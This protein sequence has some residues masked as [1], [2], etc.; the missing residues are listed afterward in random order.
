[1]QFRCQE[2]WSWQE[3]PRCRTFNE[4]KRFISQLKIT[5]TVGG[6]THNQ[7]KLNSTKI[8]VMKLENIERN[9]REQLVRNFGNN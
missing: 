4:Q 6:K 7:K 1:M 9:T 2:R 5:T 3:G 8:L